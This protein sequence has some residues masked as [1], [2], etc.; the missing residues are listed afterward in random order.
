MG[1][2]AGPP[3]S[4][5]AEEVARELADG[6]EARGVDYAVGGALG[7]AQWGVVRGTLDVD[8]NIWVDPGRPMEA[9]QLL[10]DLGCEFQTGAVVREF[11]DKGWADAAIRMRETGWRPP[12]ED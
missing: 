1:S 6:L 4:P 3:D 11:S 5:G 12:L 7:L 9:A 2:V 8:L 10:G